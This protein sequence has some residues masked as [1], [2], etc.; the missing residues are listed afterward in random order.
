MITQNL[1]KWNLLW[2]RNIF[3]FNNN[4]LYEKTLTKKADSEILWQTQVFPHCAVNN[5]VFSNY[6]KKHIFDPS[7]GFGQLNNNILLKFYN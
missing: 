1:E 2:K 5:P 6:D 3:Q 7:E 4:G